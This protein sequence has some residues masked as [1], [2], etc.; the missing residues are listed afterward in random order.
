MGFGAQEI[1]ELK[2][3]LVERMELEHQWDSSVD[4]TI[5]TGDGYHKKVTLKAIS[6]PST[7]S[8]AGILYTKLDGSDS[9][10]HYLDDAG[11]EAQLTKDGAL[12]LDNMNKSYVYAVMS[13]DQDISSLATVQFDTETYDTSSE[14]NPATYR[15]TANE[16]G[17]Y[18]VAFKINFYTE[19]DIHIYKNGSSIKNF[20]VYNLLDPYL[21]AYF[22]HAYARSCYVPLAAS[23]Y[24]EIKAAGTSYAYETFN[25]NK[26]YLSI[27]RI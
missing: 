12:N 17:L 22:T 23:D 15:F 9:E 4:T 7:M 24:I 14:Y 25:D 1:R 8:D 21:S 27:M 26:S 13:A 2:E 11:T 6:T 10:L 20:E 19:I 3:D 16:A 18:V 5:Y